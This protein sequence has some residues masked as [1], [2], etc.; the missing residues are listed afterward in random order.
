MKISKILTGS[1]L[2][3]TLLSFLEAQERDLR[4]Y[5]LINADMLFI[6]RVE[7]EY[8]TRLNG[9]VHFFYGDTEFFSDM[10]EIYEVQRIARLFG[11][12]K[13]VEDSLTLYADHAEYRRLEEHL[14]LT[15]NVFIR[16]DH[17]DGT[18]RTFRS[19]KAQYLR[20]ERRV[21]AFEN[22]YFHDERENVN[23]FCN[24]LD[25]NLTDGYGFITDNP[26]IEIVGEQNLNIVAERMEFYR[27]FNRIA[28]SFGVN[29][30]YEEY[31]ITS[32]FLLY[33]MDDEYAVFLGEPALTS[34]MADA[35]ADQFYIYFED[36]KIKSA[37]LEDNCEILF[38]IKE[39]GEKKSRIECSLMEM[40][41]TDGKISEMQAFNNVKSLYVSET[42]DRDPFMNYAESEKLIVTINS[43]SE[44]ETIVFQGRVRGQYHFS[45]KIIDN[46]ED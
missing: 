33:F 10:A 8:L 29:T 1:L 46:E 36:R 13:V 23:G 32:D 27:D 22:I 41:F 26:E 14:I 3:F 28:A 39:G 15:G 12:V 30:V 11:N 40:F 18:E 38:A 43:E 2:I 35:K 19:N 5:R 45:D 24:Y 31:L 21:Y 34:D 37:T 4:P 6:D 44:I 25:Y 42:T 17:D 20:N 9:N 7:D 16:E